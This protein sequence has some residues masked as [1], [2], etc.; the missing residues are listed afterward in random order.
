MTAACELCAQ[1]GGEVIYRCEQYRVV[2]VDDAGFPGFCRVIWNA[3]A[4]EMTDLRLLE[5]SM[6]MTAVLHV[7]QAVRD[8]MHPD[9]VNLASLGNVVPHLHWH[10]IPRYLDDT[11]FPGPVWAVAQRAPVGASLAA[12]ATLLP[13]LRQEICRLIGQP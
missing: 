8:M 13:A 3:H 1:D 12:R 9:K 4:K 2:L 5:R 10:V 7:E 6:L 11:H